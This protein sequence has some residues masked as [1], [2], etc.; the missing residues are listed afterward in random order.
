MRRVIKW[1]FVLGIFGAIGWVVWKWY[2]AKGISSD[3]LS[4]IPPDAIYCIATDDP[5]AS[6]KEISGSGPWVHLKTNTY[7]AAL[8]ASANNLDSLIRQ[9]DLLFDLI[10]SRSL[11]VSAHM[12]GF[13]QYDFLFLVDLK[14]ASGIKFINEYLTGFATSGVTVKKEKYGDNDLVVLHDPGGRSNLY[15]TM[16][17]S[18]LLASYTKKIIISALDSQHSPDSTDAERP[19][20]FIQT[21]DDL[22]NDGTLKLFVN[23]T[24][25]PQ[26]MAC[27]SSGS[28]EYVNRLS[29]TLRHTNLS[30]TVDETMVRATGH[31]YVNDSIE[32]YV[33]TLATSGK[34]PTEVME[35]IPQRTAFCLAM[36]FTS[37]SVFFENFQ[38]NVQQDVSEYATYRE[39]LKQVEEYLNI[40]LQENFINW[41]GDEI[42]LLELQSYGKGLDNETAL[43]LKADNIEKARKDLDYIEKMIRKKTPVKF[44]TVDHRGYS[45]SYLS[46]KGLFKMLLGKFFA[47]YDKPYYTIV[48][49]F[50]IFSN[51]PQTLESMID[52]YLDKKTLVRSDEFRAFRKEFDD[53]SAAFV[54]LNTPVLFNAMK[55]LADASTRVSMERN[56]EYIVCFRQVG[57][58]LVPESGGF[59]TLLAEQFVAPPLPPP[60][61]LSADSGNADSVKEERTEVP[62][63]H[64]EPEDSDP[65]ALPYIYAQNLNAS[66]FTGYFPDSTVHFEVELRNGFKDGSFT[67]YHPNGEVKMKG[68]F[69]NDKRDGAW[70]LFDDNGKLVLRRV[71]D[72]G[73]VS[74]EKVKD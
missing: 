47:R 53:E 2:G 32:S 37:F 42:A 5:I 45:I 69:K 46:M 10:G 3:A 50:V 27:Y 19:E 48:N 14:E 8:T 61:T 66:S 72:N 63:L 6:W 1:I 25:L 39:G 13:K 28:N 40:D 38:K 35:V 44:K 29:Q 62:E 67:E 70:R 15:I 64:P 55:K 33:K 41:I 49:N 18:Y 43:V 58:Q 22:T 24:M 12:T 16:P 4:L 52:D 73:E 56:K 65:M 51:H 59:K 74:K 31:T 68:H 17:G 7:F 20:S 23:Y 26:F 34:G 21:T 9:N 60:A 36:G 30:L 57:F 71:Y 11:I 54:Y